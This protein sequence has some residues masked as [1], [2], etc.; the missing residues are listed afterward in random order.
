MREPF[1]V[2]SPV[3]TPSCFRQ[4][5]PFEERVEMLADLSGKTALVTGGGQGI[6][7]GIV[8]AMAEQGADVAIA[9][10]NDALDTLSAIGAIETTHRDETRIARLSARLRQKN[11]HVDLVGLA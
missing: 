10:I 8:L 4:R 3:G 1:V 9:D 5:L 11:S 6:G 7:R 2:L